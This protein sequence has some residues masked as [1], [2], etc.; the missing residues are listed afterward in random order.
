MSNEECERLKDE[1]YAEQEIS[2]LRDAMQ[3]L[4]DACRHDSD[5]MGWRVLVA[6]DRAEEVLR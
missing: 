3:Q 4:L 6:M 5:S 1:I 2:R